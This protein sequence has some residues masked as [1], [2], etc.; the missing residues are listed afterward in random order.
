MTKVVLVGAGGYGRW[1]LEA[2]LR[3]QNA[4]GFRL[5]GVVEKVAG[6]IDSDLAGALQREGIPV[7]DDLAALLGS[8]GSCDLVVLSTPI[9]FH[10]EQTCLSLRHGASVLC[11]KPLCSSLPEI[12]KMLRAE[13]AAGKTVTIG[14]QWSFTPAIQKLKADILAGRFGRP[15]RLKSLAGLPRP[16][17]YYERNSWAG[18]CHTDLGWPVFDSPVNN[19]AAHFLHNMLYVLG[20]SRSESAEVVGAEA[21]LWR[22]HD[23]ENFDTAAVRL[24]TE[25]QTEILF[26][27]SHAVEGREGPRFSYEFELGTVDYDTS[28]S[29]EGVINA[30]LKTGELIDYGSPEEGYEIK[31]WNSLESART[32]SAPLCG[33]AAAACHTRA[34]LMIQEAGGDICAFPDSLK[35]ESAEP[36]PHRYVP[37][38]Q[39]ALRECYVKGILLRDLG[40]RIFDARRE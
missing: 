29:P 40:E 15:I 12:E 14:Y 11:E 10:A 8:I 6:A 24:W 21:D 22:L 5:A 7:F 3:E 20:P 23:I 2:L 33:I 18:R 30:S 25:A 36:F 32:N 31:L 16:V 27:A 17:G 39:P 38:L 37:E 26:Y 28:A 1:Y 35:K 9:H 34:V 4:R 13:S 19:A